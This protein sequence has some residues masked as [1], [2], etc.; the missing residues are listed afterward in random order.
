VY[1]CEPK[2]IGLNTLR[3]Y[4]SKGINFTPGLVLRVFGY[5]IRVLGIFACRDIELLLSKIVL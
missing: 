4:L 2:P 3:S 5:L 1:V